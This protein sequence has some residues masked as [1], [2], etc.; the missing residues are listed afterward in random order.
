MF[1]NLALACMSLMLVW[2]SIIGQCGETKKLSF[3]TITKEGLELK[4]LPVENEDGIPTAISCM[5]FNSGEK[6]IVIKTSSIH[7]DRIKPSVN[8]LIDPANSTY[9]SFS[10][11][12]T[13]ISGEHFQPIERVYFIEPQAFIGVQVP[14]RDVCRAEFKQG[15]LVEFRGSITIMTG[16][17]ENNLREVLLTGIGKYAINPSL[18]AKEK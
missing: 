5:L 17:D 18:S 1:K 16:P 3:E 7:K 9:K 12:N 6:C 10:S 11:A 15:N 8:I 4:F 13:L 2:F 14:I